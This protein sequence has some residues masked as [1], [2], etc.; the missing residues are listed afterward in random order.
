MNLSEEYCRR[1]TLKCPVIKRPDSHLNALFHADRDKWGSKWVIFDVA[2]KH[3]SYHPSYFQ[4]SWKSPNHNGTFYG[5]TFSRVGPAE[6]VEW[7]DY[8]IEILRAAQ[9]DNSLR[10]V[11]DPQ[12][13]RLAFWEVFLFTS[14]E[15]VPQLPFGVRQQICYSLDRKKSFEA[16]T[17]ALSNIESFFHETRSDMLGYWNSIALYSDPSIYAYWFMELS[18]QMRDDDYR[19]HFG[20]IENVA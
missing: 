2:L 14:D 7:D 19:K 5:N 12:E 20:S 1:H 11:R 17:K 6:R 8:D 13:S 10:P 18:Q 15:R 3:E 9:R 16:R 4:F